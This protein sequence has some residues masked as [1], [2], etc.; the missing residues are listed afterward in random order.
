[1]GGFVNCVDAF[2]VEEAGEEEGNCGEEGANV[3]GVEGGEGDC[4]EFVF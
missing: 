1:M 2:G 4:V 3:P